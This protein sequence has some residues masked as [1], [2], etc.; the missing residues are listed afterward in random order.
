[1]GRLPVVA[2]VGRANVGKSTLTNRLIGRRAA[3]EHPSPGVTR[4]RQGY[5][6]TW[7]GEPFLL[8]DTG[9]WEPKAKGLGAKVR[10][11]AERAATEADLILMIVD[12]QVG[13]VEDDLVV[14]RGLRKAP[15]PVVVIANKVDSLA[16]EAELG[17]LE[18]LGLG[19]ALP[20]SALHG[21]GSGDLLDVV[22]EHVRAADTSGARE[23]G[24]DVAVAIVGR[25]NVG[26]SSLFNKLVGDERSIVHDMPGTT[27]DTV[28]TIADLD[29]RRYRFIDTAGMRRRAK[30][31]QGPEY[32]GLVRSLRA[33]DEADVVL[34]LIDATE[35]ATEQDQK[36]AR[37]VA[38][39]G[40]A[41]V[42]VLNK[43]DLVEGEEAHQVTLD[44]RDMLRFVPWAQ[45]VRTSALTG[46]GLNKIVP[47]IDTAR[48]AWEQRIPTA[49]LNTWL[50]EVVE[51]IRLGDTQRARPTRIKYVT[52]SSVRPPTFVLFSNGTVS[53]TAVRALEN[54]LRER[55]GF[56]GTP[57]R[58][59]VR[60]QV[61]KTDAD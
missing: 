38:D 42:V 30:E 53:A 4:D 60:K 19:P 49:A 33:I 29:G 8:V 27:R 10:A 16:G 15:V 44:T 23:P 58:M 32:Y 7:R 47:A 18:R 37:R 13:I 50:R 57:V 21:R 22:V 45:F 48:A 54:R 12:A 61:R 20:V 6:M 31:A 14:A 59:V 46:R 34:H 55:F 43:W 51:R 25:P 56:E 3:I 39:A 5:E 11:Q 2:V 35:L 36:I 40:C 9:G 41:A 1:M 28:D 17:L 26:K 24:A 52:Q